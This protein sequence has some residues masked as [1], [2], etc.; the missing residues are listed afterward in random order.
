MI[1]FKVVCEGG[2][3][4]RDLLKGDAYVIVRRDDVCVKPLAAKPLSDDMK[5]KFIEYVCESADPTVGSI[6]P[7]LIGGYGDS[8]GAGIGAGEV[9]DSGCSRYDGSWQWLIRKDPIFINAK[10]DWVSCSGATSQDVLKNQVDTINNPDVAL[11]NIGGNDAKLADLLNDCVYNFFLLRRCSDTIEISQDATSKLQ[12]DLEDLLSNMLVKIPNENSKIFVPG[13]ATF[14][15]PDTTQCNEVTFD[16]RQR[17]DSNAPKLAKEQRKIYN[18]LTVAVNTAVEQAT[19]TYPDRVVYIDIDKDFTDAKGRFCAD[20]V[21]EPDLNRKETLFFN[22]YQNQSAKVNTDLR[23][24]SLTKPP[25]KGTFERSIYDW[26]VADYIAN[27]PH[28][29]LRKRI[30][31]NIPPQAKGS[32]KNAIGDFVGSFIPDDIKRVF[33]PVP[34]CHEIIAS[35]VLSAMKPYMT[36]TTYNANNC[37]PK[38]GG[39]EPPAATPKPGDPLPKFLDSNSPVGSP[40]CVEGHKNDVKLDDLNPDST[41]D[42]FCLSESGKTTAILPYDAAKNGKACAWFPKLRFERAKS[43]PPKCGQ[44]F[45]DY[46]PDDET[47]ALCTNPL[48]DIVN[49]CKRVDGQDPLLG[50]GG[51]FTDA[52]GT[53]TIT[54]CKNGEK[55]CGLVS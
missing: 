12:K 41:I 18:D 24:R 51:S 48:K 27:P 43:A 26:V 21:T 31:Q 37:S 53:W 35:Q 4:R 11:L 3:R 5:P 38:T 55:G 15:N 42:K 7:K 9:K 20:G 44:L 1:K 34:A 40:K 33:H 50:R 19:L 2:N 14:F 36:A 45:K 32:E 30:P 39:T 28:D 16:Y 6:T 29:K 22:Y 47:R 17:E 25:S 13:Y 46:L 52:C 8:Y 10:F 49:A 54:T 23:R